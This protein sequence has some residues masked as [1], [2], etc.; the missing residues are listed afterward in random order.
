MK[1]KKQQVLETVIE[2]HGRE[3]PVSRANIAKALD[4][5]KPTY[6]DDCL[7]ELVDD[8]LIYRVCSGV[9]AP[10]AQHPPARALYKT[11]LPDGIVKL[12]IGDDVLTLTPKEARTLGGLMYAEATEFG[13]LSLKHH[14]L[15]QEQA[16]YNHLKRLEKEISKQN[17]PTQGE[18]L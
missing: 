15:E 16:F 8:E 1:S 3:I 13:L 18:L 10:V 9:Y 12:E 17:K 6:I 2:L 11:I 4:D 7:K 5:I 14:M